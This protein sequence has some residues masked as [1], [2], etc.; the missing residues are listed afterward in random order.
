MAGSDERRVMLRDWWTVP[1]VPEGT[2]R[3]V[4]GERTPDP[5]V[6]FVGLT[7][8]YYVRAHATRWL[9][10]ERVLE[11]MRNRITSANVWDLVSLLAKLGIAEEFFDLAAVDVDRDGAFRRFL[12][13][14]DPVLLDAIR[15]YSAWNAINPKLFFEGFVVGVADSFATVVVDL[16]RLVQLIVRLQQEQFRTLFL[17]STDPAAGVLR[18]DR[19]ALVVRQ[20]FSGVVASLNPAAV[21]DKVLGVWRGWEQEFERHLENLDPFEAGRLLGRIAG[22]LWQLLTGIAALVKLLRVT[23]RAAARYV[24]LLLQ[25]VRGVAAQGRLVVRELA[26]L[27]VA[28]GKAA[29]EGAPR[30]G[31]EFLRTLFPPEVLRPLIQ[32]GRALLVHGDLSLAVVFQAAHAEAFAGAGAG[33]RFGVLVS[34]ENKPLFMAAMSETVSSAGRQATRAELDEALDAIL[35][36]LDDFLAEAKAPTLMND[37]SAAAVKAARAAQLEQRLSTHLNRRLQEVAYGAFLDLRKAGRVNP[38]ELGQLVHQRMAAEVGQLIAQGPPGL[39]VFTERSLRTTIEALR[40][41]S[42]EFEA[43][44]KGAGGALDRTVAQMLLDRPDRDVLLK[45]IGF[46]AN[47]AADT[48]KALAS[49]LSKQFGW[50]ASTTVGDL[51]SDLLLVD[52]ATRRV[53]NIDWTSSTKLDAHE[54]AWGKVVDDLGK[55]FDGNWEAIAQAY[56]QAL[57]DGPPAEVLRHLEHLTRHAVR[58][59]VVRQAALRSVFG[60]TWFVLSHEM[61]YKG[62]NSLF[63]K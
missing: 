50:K 61:L 57:G 7:V 8:Q 51:Q 6:E 43:A 14:L 47:A 12:L 49:H 38:R 56:Q 3:Q 54:R 23:A 22:D 30:V 62:L 26:A 36:G 10:R 52:P 1:A 18:I 19:Q 5:R 20:A 24:P 29:V 25:T 41:S 44:L 15:H 48:E 59:T 13:T 33:T 35:V 11:A 42:P 39:K 45:L 17:L 4:Y 46:E 2:L 32:Q 28:L 31:M 60:E 27:L 53:T 16:G 63:K 21:P 58:E 40:A 37:A 55:D 9:T 34:R